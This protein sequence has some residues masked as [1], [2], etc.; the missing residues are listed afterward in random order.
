MPAADPATIPGASE[1]AR[2]PCGDRTRPR[3]I[4]FDMDGVLVDSEPIHQ[5]ACN[6][7]L[8][9]EG[10]SLT[11]EEYASYIGTT[12]ESTWDGLKERL[13][14]SWDIAEYK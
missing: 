1:S 10:K 11:D 3:A 14:L 4:V 12:I 7:I 5:E 8:A 6:A 9:R 2:P 13:G